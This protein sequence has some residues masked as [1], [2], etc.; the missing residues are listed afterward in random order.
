MNVSQSKVFLFF[1]VFFNVICMLVQGTAEKQLLLMLSPCLN[2]FF[3][4]KTCVG[5][6]Y[7]FAITI[8]KMV[9]YASNF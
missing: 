8:M 4:L 9:L 2:N 6:L 1:F 5:E 3:F 7:Y